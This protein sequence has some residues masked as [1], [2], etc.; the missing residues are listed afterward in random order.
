MALAALDKFS[1]DDKEYDAEQDSVSA[2]V[3]RRELSLIVGRMPQAFVPY[4]HCN[5]SS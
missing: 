5:T 2:G 1:A 3:L 4:S